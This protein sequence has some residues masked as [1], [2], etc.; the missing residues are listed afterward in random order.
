MNPAGPDLGQSSALIEQLW[1]GPARR[2]SVSAIESPPA[3][4][5]ADSDLVTGQVLTVDGGWTHR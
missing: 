5:A 2:M 1:N 3:S 4:I